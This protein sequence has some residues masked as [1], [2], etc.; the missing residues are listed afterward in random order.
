MKSVNEER[1]KA[2]Y[3]GDNVI[4]DVKKL[5]QEDLEVY[6]WNL[7]IYQD[8]CPKQYQ[9]QV[10]NLIYDEA[11]KVMGGAWYDQLK[12]DVYYYF[13]TL[14]GTE[15]VEP[16][17]EFEDLECFLNDRLNAN[18]IEKGGRL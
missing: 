6:A 16:E 2:V 18:F 1:T 8:Y 13:E 7:L 9:E 11:H 15:E 5:L 3:A 10:F 17:P 4:E 12:D 14:K